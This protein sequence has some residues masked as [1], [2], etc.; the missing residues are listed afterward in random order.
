MTGGRYYTDY[1]KVKEIL[2]EESPWM[3]IQG[4]ASGADAL[5]KKWCL[6]NGVRCVTFHA[7]WDFY[8]KRA[9][10]L[11]NEWMLELLTRMCNDSSA[12]IR[13]L[14]F[15]GGKGT[16]NMTTKATEWFVEVIEIPGS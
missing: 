5:A 9:G 7:C 4:G 6:A 10:G 8:G 16:K 14:A 2:D 1:D 12:L 3:V 13:V 11:R 15:P